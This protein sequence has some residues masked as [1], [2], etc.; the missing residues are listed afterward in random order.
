MLRDDHEANAQTNYDAIGCVQAAGQVEQEGGSKGEALEHVGLVVWQSA[1]LLAELLVRRPPFGGWGDVRCVDLGT[2]TGVCS[3]TIPKHLSALPH[4]P[5]AQVACTHEL[6]CTHQPMAVNVL[7]TP[8]TQGVGH[9]GFTSDACC[10]M[11]RCGGHCTG[12]G[13][14]RRGR[15]RPA[16]C[17][18][19]HPR[20]RWS[21]LRF[22]T[23]PLPGTVPASCHYVPYCGEA[24]AAINTTFYY[25]PITHD[26]VLRKDDLC[27][28]ILPVGREGIGS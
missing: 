18:T 8:Q 19:A 26:L 2:G 16:A 12:E 9:S 22:F 5:P 3:H 4:Q 27:K 11:G 20:K 10:A 1:F 6:T 28:R 14:C 25:Q 13:G 7:S 21:Q 23:A 24:R 15:C 17:N